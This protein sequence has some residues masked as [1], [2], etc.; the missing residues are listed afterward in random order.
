MRTDMANAAAL[1]EL[2]RKFLDYEL[3]EIQEFGMRGSSSKL[4][5]PTL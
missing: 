4:T 3:P 2:I 5:C 1:D